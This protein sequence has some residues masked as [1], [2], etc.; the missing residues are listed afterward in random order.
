MSLNARTAD[1]AHVMDQL[2]PEQ[3]A[4]LDHR[5]DQLQAVLGKVLDRDSP[6][7]M[8]VKNWLN[9][10]WL[11]HPLHPALTDIPIGA[12]CT[13]AFLDLAGLAEAADAAYAVSILGA[14]PTALSGAADWHDV[15]GEPRRTGLVH[16]L[17]NSVGVGF[18][19]ASLCARRGNQRTLGV[20]L[21]TAGLSCAAVSA[22]LGGH[23]VYT[24][25]TGV[26]RTAFEPLVEDFTAVAHADAVDSGR[27]VPAEV[28]VDGARVSLVLFKQGQSLTAI[29]A[30][31]TH[32]GG[33][34]AEGRLVDSD[35]VECPLHGSRFSLAD[36]S[37][38]QGPASIPAFQFDVRA[39]NGNI[40]VRRQR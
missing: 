32:A 15:A 37:V 14:I 20:M 11:G 17:L 30:T 5:A 22:W 18:K 9:G 28:D 12:W 40:E 19:L 27:L 33:N 10:T 38:R 8:H 1:I 25:G 13:G 4:M 6:T 31:C 26:S 21:S 35:C 3:K 24:L 16:A 23:L 2:P 39:R 7:A 29:N 36:G 34:L